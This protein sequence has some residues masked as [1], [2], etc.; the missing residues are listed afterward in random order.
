MCKRYS[1]SLL[2]LSFHRDRERERERER[3]LSPK[4]VKLFVIVACILMKNNN[5]Y[6]SNEL[7]S[8][9]ILFV[10]RIAFISDKFQRVDCSCHHKWLKGH[11]CE[12]EL[13]P[14]DVIH[15]FENVTCNNNATDK[16]HPC[17]PCP[18]GYFENG[19]S[20]TG[21]CTLY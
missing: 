9:L 16:D 21:E 17:G 10:V 20:C 18:T 4:I 11:F 12:T 1:S 8:F 14:C 7:I 2:F 6:T 3:D 5:F 19:D 15:C 13:L